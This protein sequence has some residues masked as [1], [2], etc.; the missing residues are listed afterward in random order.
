MWP[1]Y[2]AEASLNRVAVKSRKKGPA[3]SGAHNRSQA[4]HRT[5]AN[6]RNQLAHCRFSH[7]PG[8][9]PC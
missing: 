9:R 6:Q 5:A 3:A 8:C 2:W 7:L 4:L 1:R